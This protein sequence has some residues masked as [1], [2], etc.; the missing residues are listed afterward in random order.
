MRIRVMSFN[1]QHCQSYV[2]GKIDF[3]IF[4]KELK[5]VG[6]EIIGL[7]EMRNKG[8]SEDYQDQVGILAKALGYN[9]YFAEAIRVK[10]VNPYGNGILS[11]YPILSAET[12]MIPDPKSE[13]CTSKI[14]TRCILHAKI[15]A[16]QGVIDVFVTHFGLS[17][18]EQKNAVKT[19]IANITDTKTIL[20]GDFNVLPSDPVLAPIRERMTDTA[21]LSDKELLSHPS[22]IPDKKIDYMFTSKDI[23]TLFADVPAHVVS[24]HRPYIS[25]L[26]F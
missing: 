1:T 22:D 12:V 13:E 24:D 7:N 11:K 9:S 25:E 26:E 19:V 14:E 2:T 5:D 3:D 17:H 15:D 4:V 8:E 6:A 10:G 16:P 20:M 21:E 18:A 23:K